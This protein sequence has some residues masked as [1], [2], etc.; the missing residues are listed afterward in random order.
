MWYWLASALFLLALLSKPIAVVVPLI[1]AILDVGIHRRPAK[2]VLLSLVPW[3]ALA[4]IFGLVA[5]QVQP[6]M[7]APLCAVR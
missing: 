3:F 6:A 1:A 7:E 5:R 2:R 4:V